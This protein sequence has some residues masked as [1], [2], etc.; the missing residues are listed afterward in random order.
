MKR[1]T[2]LFLAVLLL[3]TVAIVPVGAEEAPTRDINDHLTIHYD[4]LGS[5][6]EERLKDKAPAGAAAG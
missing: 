5:T 6:T 1:L 4:F 3:A 2:G